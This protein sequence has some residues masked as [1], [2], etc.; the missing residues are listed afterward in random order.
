MRN[1]LLYIPAPFLFI[2]GSKMTET[3]E[4]KILHELEELKAENIISLDVRHCTTLTDFMVIASG[5]STRH[6]LA[7]SEH[8]VENLKAKGIRP[9]R[10]EGQNTGEW[11]IVD[12]GDVIVHIMQP[13][14]REF[15]ELEKLW[16]EEKAA[17]TSD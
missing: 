1:K 14:T 7:I 10:T 11:V 3:L 16:G 17:C 6:T 4:Q 13:E 2:S 9:L 8:L 12:F 15:Y 5:R